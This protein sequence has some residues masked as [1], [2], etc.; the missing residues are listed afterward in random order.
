MNDRLRAYFGG[1]ANAL[2]E[3]VRQAL[4]I[5]HGD[6]LAALR[7]VIIANT[8]LQEENERLRQQISTGFTRGGLR[9]V[10]P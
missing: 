9:K 2:E 3:S 10:V 6:A 1:Q 4:E 5:T 7:T 8:F